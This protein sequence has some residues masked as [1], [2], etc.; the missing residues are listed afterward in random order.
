MPDPDGPRTVRDLERRLAGER[1]DL[2]GR[3]QVPEIATIQS[4]ARSLRRRRR[5][6]SGAAALAM[7]GVV[8]TGVLALRDQPGPPP[9]PAAPAFQSIW[10][11][12]GLTLYGLTAPVLN[13]DGDLYDVQFADASRGFALASS[14]PG[15]GDVCDI[16]YAVTM[17][18]GRTWHPRESPIARAPVDALPAL[19][20]FGTEH[21]GV[22]GETA[23]VWVPG[24]PGAWAPMDLASPPL[25][26]PVPPGGRLWTRSGPTCQPGPLYVWQL[27]GPL[28][29]LA[30]PPPMQVCRVV[31]APGGA[32]WAGGYVRGA[33]RRPAV[34]VSR[35]AGRTWRLIEL[36]SS[37]GDA[38]AQVS[39]LGTDVYVSVVSLRGGEPYPDTLRLHAVY[40]SAAG[41]DFMP[42]GPTGGTLV[43]DLVPL[44][45]GGLV[46]AGPLWYVSRDGGRLEKDDGSLPFVRRLSRT[47]GAWIAYDLFQGGWTAISRDGVDWHKLNVH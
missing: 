4:R 6:A 23:W 38:W 35:N 45:D 41:Q 11:G 14:C 13:V 37:S 33:D 27:A 8:S 25:V 10:R 29:V 46:V 39:P 26:S 24:A 19:V 7:L 28:G 1:T 30:T 2:L 12:S 42:Y 22:I 9:T 32:W 20:P 40:R 44:L 47:T 16:A 15:R 17:D 31:S 21:V 5:L 3:I 34:A 36:P 43:G 18:G